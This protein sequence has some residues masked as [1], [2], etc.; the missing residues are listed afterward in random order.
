MYE[1]GF[2]MDT[3]KHDQQLQI[4][5]RGKQKL[6]IF[7]NACVFADWQQKNASAFYTLQFRLSCLT[8]CPGIEP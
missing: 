7:L 3:K 2:A 4:K 5:K 6:I 1:A 8:E